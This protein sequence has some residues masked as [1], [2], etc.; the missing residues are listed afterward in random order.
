MAKRAARGLESRT[1]NLSVRLTKSERVRIEHRAAAAGLTVSA[2]AA[3]L[4]A[5]GQVTVEAKPAA[6]VM[7]PELIAEFKRIGNNLNQIAHALNARMPA[8][9]ARLPRLW[10]DFINAILR[11]E[12]LQGRAAPFAKAIQK[13]HDRRSP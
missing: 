7:A 8:D 4:L 3:Q 5:K 13:S 11:D 10:N 12:Y 1:E 2:W 6:V 9:H